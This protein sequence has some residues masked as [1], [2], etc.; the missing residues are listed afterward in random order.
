MKIAKAARA[1]KNAHEE[2]NNKRAEPISEQE[3]HKFL[4]EK[5]QKKA[6][7]QQAAAASAAEALSTRNLGFVDSLFG[8]HK[9]DGGSTLFD[10]IIVPCGVI[11]C[12]LHLALAFRMWSRRTHD[13][14]LRVKS[15]TLVLIQSVS[16]TVWYLGFVVRFGHF[17]KPES[18]V[19]AACGFWNYYMSIVFGFG[20]WSA[21]ILFR[22]LRLYHFF[23]LNGSHFRVPGLGALSF[24]EDWYKV[25]GVLAT[26]LAV[27]YGIILPLLGDN[28]HKKVGSKFICVYEGKLWATLDTVAFVATWALLF[29]LV[30]SLRRVNDQFGALQCI[31]FGSCA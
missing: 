28:V 16:G 23:V 21:C 11:I 6:S 17:A 9:M 3:Y 2:R 27:T 10:F 22:L 15:L 8:V 5:A 29:Y 26:P 14:A 30:H 18:G 7:R 1:I 25:L 4:E 19:F 24:K 12:G 31:R 13:V 20:V